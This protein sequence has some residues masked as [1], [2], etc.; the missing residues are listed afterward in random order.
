MKLTTKYKG[1]QP[2]AKRL[3]REIKRLRSE[4]FTYN[5]LSKITGYALMT[6]RKYAMGA[7]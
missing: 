1:R 6:V 5:E 3:Q 2:I 7:K 4:G